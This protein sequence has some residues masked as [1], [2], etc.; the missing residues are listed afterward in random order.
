M[1]TVFSNVY[2]EKDYSSYSYLQRGDRC[3]HLSNDAFKVE[4]SD[5]IQTN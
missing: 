2:K 5:R 3:Y 4:K 1:C